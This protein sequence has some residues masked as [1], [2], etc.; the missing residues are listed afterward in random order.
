MNSFRPLCTFAL[1]VASWLP[2]ASG[3]CRAC[4]RIVYDADEEI[5]EANELLDGL[6]RGS[7]LEAL[8]VIRSRDP[9]GLLRMNREDREEDV[10]RFL[11]ALRLWASTTADDF[12]VYRVLDG[13]RHHDLRLTDL[14]LDALGH[15]SPSVRRTAVRWLAGNRVAR[16]RARLEAMWRAEGR[17]WMRAELALALGC[18]DLETHLDKVLELSRSNETSP[19]AAAL[20]LLSSHRAVEATRALMRIAREGPGETAEIAVY[21]L[22]GHMHVSGVV[23]LLLDLAASGIEDVEDSAMDVLGQYGLPEARETIASLA[24]DAEDAWT[25]RIAIEALAA[26]YPAERRELLG[27]VLPDL[28]G[29]EAVHATELLGEPAQQWELEDP[30]IHREYASRMLETEV[31]SVSCY[32][33]G[34]DESYLLPE[35]VVV[36]AAAGRVTARCWAA[37]EIADP[38]L[39]ARLAAG[40]EASVETMFESANELWYEIVPAGR[41]ESCWIALT[42]D[43]PS[44]AERRPAAAIAEFDADYDA[45]STRAMQ[46]LSRAGVLELFE[47]ATYSTGVAVSISPDDLE[48]ATRT[49]EAY[50]LSSPTLR[51][52]L[53]AA[54]RQLQRAHP[55]WAL[56]GGLRDRDSRAGPPEAARTGSERT[57]RVPASPAH[58][59]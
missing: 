46:M 38:K 20:D 42:P 2:L 23:D 3:V 49:V 54:I 32:G 21:E 56:G 33:R 7:R 31:S 47:E 51:R 13:L 39:N 6:Y 58:A 15:T 55:E 43:A 41:T 12:L 52:H 29:D 50:H 14:Y 37:P 48:A 53:A 40:T 18:Q 8:D 25:R 19:V 1:V 45:L 22:Q 27:R 9:R 44:G 26:G 24:T 57:L 59:P 30:A 10:Q 11:V 5:L 35:T 4:P 34:L 16:S 36:T 17:P 28:D